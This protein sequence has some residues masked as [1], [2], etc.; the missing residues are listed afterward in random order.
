MTRVCLAV[1]ISICLSLT[2]VAYG[3]ESVVQETS[4]ASMKWYQINTN[5]FRVLYPY[6]FE[7]EAQRVANTLEHI[8]EPEAK[9]LEAMPKKISVVLHSQSAV[10]NGFVTLAPRRSEFYAMP[11]QNYNFI[12]TN[13]WLTLLSAHEY[14]HIVQFQ[15]V[16]PVLIRVSIFYSGSWLRRGWHL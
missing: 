3:Q 13:E 2:K 4:P 16:L 5:N 9:S 1:S 7:R 14:R 12:G 10:S 6:G 11:P 8:R 15:K